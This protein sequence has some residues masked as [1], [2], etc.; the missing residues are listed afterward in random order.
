LSDSFKNIHR[1]FHEKMEEMRKLKVYESGYFMFIDKYGPSNGVE[2]RDA[3]PT[4]LRNKGK[5][6]IEKGINIK[7]LHLVQF[8]YVE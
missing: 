4:H 6:I 1:E 5:I 8:I 7:N 2:I 3:I